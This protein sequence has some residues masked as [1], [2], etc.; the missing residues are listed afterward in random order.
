MLQARP[1]VC[2]LLT[3]AFAFRRPFMGLVEFEVRV[4]LNSSGFMCPTPSEINRDFLGV[5]IF[6]EWISLVSELVLYLF[7]ATC[8]YLLP[9]IG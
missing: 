6:V 4:L 3:D 2:L 8:S 1:A 5:Y 7:L 9:D